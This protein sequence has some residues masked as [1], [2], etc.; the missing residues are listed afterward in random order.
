MGIYDRD[1]IQDRPRRSV[2]RQGPAG[3]ASAG[4]SVNT[5]IIAINVAVFVVG[6]FTSHLGI[7]VLTNSGPV[8]VETESNAYIQNESFKVSP[9]RFA[10]GAEIRGVNGVLIKEYGNP[11]S[12]IQGPPEFIAERVRMSPA[13]GMFEHPT[14][15][16]LAVGA[17]VIK[18]DTYRVMDP[19]AALGHFSTAKV[20]VDPRPIPGGTEY[21]FALEVWR[22]L[23]FQFLHAGFLH[24]FFNMF[25]L[26][27]FGGLVEQ[28]LGRKQYLSFYLVC[29]IAGGVMYLILN[30]LGAFT[31]IRLPGVLIGDIHT[32][33]VGASAGVFGVIMAA[34]FITPNSTVML[35]FPPIPLKLKWIAYGYVAIA[36]YNLLTG[37]NNAGGDAAH[38]GGALGGY[39]FIRNKHLLKDMLG[40]GGKDSG[41]TR[42]KKQKVGAPS[43]SEIDKIL[44][45]VH[46]KGLKSLTDT[47]KRKLSEASREP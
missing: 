1:Y 47:E 35:L 26:F 33:L 10:T 17:Q 28:Y 22:L 4:W 37:G 38:I 11:D 23:T 12:A 2:F 32:P 34:A 15:P 39:Y 27:I 43:D 7:P 6:M 21:V 31:P 45:K 18:V 36:L 41:W 8:V 16:D 44:L 20:F 19:L 9:S 25:G 40:R 30:F 5:W 24:L 46:E 14:D 13:L 42:P 3:M 29:G